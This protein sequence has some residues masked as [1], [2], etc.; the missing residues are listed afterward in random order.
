MGMENIGDDF[1][2]MDD[3]IPDEGAGN[4][5]VDILKDI[6]DLTKKLEDV[7]QKLLDSMQ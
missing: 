6:G 2:D 7:K 5:S 1:D 3:D 4:N